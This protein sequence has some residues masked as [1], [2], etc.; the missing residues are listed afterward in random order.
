[1]ALPD[2]VI[3]GAGIVG[4]ACA[5]YAADAGL[6]V[7]VLDRGPIAGGTTAAGQ[8]IALAANRPP[9]PALDLAIESLRRWEELDAEL[10]GARMELTRKGALTVAA[11]DAELDALTGLA[12]GYR[13]AGVDAVEVPAGELLDREP[14]LAPD[15]SG[16]VYYPA[17]VQVDPVLATAHLLRA[18]GAEIRC[19]VEVRGLE[20]DGGS[21]VTGVRTDGGRLGCAAVVNA[22]GVWAGG[23]AAMV[24]TTLPVSPRRGF[25]LVTEAL[26]AAPRRSTASRR[27]PVTRRTAP[28]IRHIVHAAGY[29][30]A[31]ASD[32]PEAR[33]AGVVT[34]GRAGTVLI[35]SSRE[36]VGFDPSWPLSLLRGLAAEAVRLFPFLAGVSAVRVCRGYRP[37]TPDRLP[38]IGPDPWVTGLFHACGHEGAGVCLAP[39]TGALTARLLTT[40]TAPDGFA[41]DPERFG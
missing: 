26:G 9:G 5:F 13:A 39:A 37:D 31:V 14:R 38:I 25:M 29:A 1:M 12:A 4:A 32:D 28:P 30:G 36:R 16:G 27:G 22:A 35:G 3:I 40:G 19:G 34:C 11:N 7:T 18:S 6:S 21:R 24:G 17:G 23:V 41:F 10:G 15:L 33:V 20:L 2:V 8:G